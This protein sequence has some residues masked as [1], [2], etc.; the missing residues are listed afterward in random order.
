MIMKKIIA[1]FAAAALIF[2]GASVLPQASVSSDAVIKASA[3]GASGKCGENA[4]WV[5]D[6][7]GTLI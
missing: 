1:V 7:S 5:L 6:E 3:A 4:T 2:A